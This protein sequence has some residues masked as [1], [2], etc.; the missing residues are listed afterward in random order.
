MITRVAFNVALF[1]ILLGGVGAFVFRARSGAISVVD[2]VVTV[3]LGALWAG[4]LVAVIETRV[5]AVERAALR[6]GL[7]AL[8]GAA[9]YV[10]LFAGV[11]FLAGFG[12]EPVFFSLA[13]A[14]GGGSHALRA[15][16]YGGHDEGES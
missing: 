15:R 4:V 1:A 12:A 10:G 5:Y 13:L 3:V 2:V 8:C 11:S 7:A 14:L 16:L 6:M 9:A